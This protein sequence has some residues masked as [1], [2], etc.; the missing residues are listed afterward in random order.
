V[1]T[2]VRVIALGTEEFILITTF[3]K[4]KKKNRSENDGKTSSN[5][6]G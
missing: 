5:C 1:V 3:L 4:T 6:G 2:V